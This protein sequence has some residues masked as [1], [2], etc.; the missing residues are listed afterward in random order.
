[1]VRVMTAPWSWCRHDALQAGGRRRPSDG[2][3]LDRRCSERAHR[4]AARTSRDVHGSHLEEDATAVA[5]KYIEQ[6][7]RP[8]ISLR[9]SQRFGSRLRRTNP[10][11]IDALLATAFLVVVLVGH[12]AANDAGVDYHDPDLW[13][14]LLTIGVAV[15]YVFRRHAPLAVLLTSEAAVVL[16]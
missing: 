3:H 1:S 4:V 10:W 6:V 5:D 16:L 11:V 12:F 7:E 14:V 2:C 15:P 9:L 8:P 13:S